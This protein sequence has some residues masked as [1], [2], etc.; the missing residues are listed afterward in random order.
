MRYHIIALL[1]LL[2]F[3][4][5]VW[6]Q[7]SITN[8]IAIGGDQTQAVKVTG[9]AK[10]A[11]VLPDTLGLEQWYQWPNYTKATGGN[12][13]W[14]D[15]GPLGNNATNTTDSKAPTVGSGYL[16]FNGSAT[17]WLLGNTSTGF[18]TATSWTHVF[19]A[20]VPP[21]SVSWGL[22]YSNCALGQHRVIFSSSG[23][24]R[25]TGYV[26]NTNAPCT[27]DFWDYGNWHTY[28]IV[29][30]DLL[31]GH[32]SVT[33]YRDGAQIGAIGDCAANEVSTNCSPGMWIFGYPP[34]NYLSGSCNLKYWLLYNT[35]KSAA[36][37]HAITTYLQ[38]LP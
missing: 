7:V 16:V 5:P 15:S 19:R 11:S 31:N 38:G 13:K 1:T 28:A 18:L 30:T 3:A 22:T 17:Q 32:T 33:W 8:G 37:I 25:P 24:L 27:A 29:F 12:S 34:G 21:L 26:N 6:A 2:A 23:T 9:A 35:S 14:L 20:K 36:Q 4:L 10:K